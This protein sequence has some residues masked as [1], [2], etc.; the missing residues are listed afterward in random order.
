MLSRREFLRALSF[1]T[2]VLSHK[3]THA[4]MYGD[5]A[6]IP[7]SIPHV[8]D[9][10]RGRERLL[11][12]IL[13]PE[14]MRAAA[15]LLRDVK[16]GYT[17]LPHT[18]MLTLLAWFQAV[19]ALHGHHETLIITSGARRRDTNALIEGAADNSRHIPNKDGIFSAADLQP[20]RLSINS[21]A[22]VFA[23]AKFGGIGEYKSHLHIDYGRIA[24]W[25]S[26]RKA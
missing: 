4:Q 7:A 21:V 5:S 18:N 15:H 1:S 17:A 14:G 12:D 23:H 19:V 2:V 20:T 13:T 16:A 8:I 6:R 26:Y 11:I 22:D 10:Q 9:L 25:S 3:T 24:R